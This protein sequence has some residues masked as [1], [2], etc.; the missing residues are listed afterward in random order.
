MKNTPESIE[1]LV[2]SLS[3]EIKVAMES[4]SYFYPLY[5]RLEDAVVEVKAAH[6]LKVRLIADSKIKSDKIDALVLAQLL[7]LG[8]PANQLHPAQGDS[9][10]PRPAP[11]QDQ[12]R[13][14]ENPGEE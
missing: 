12:P 9:P 2:D 10:S 7:R 14:A 5:N 3:P 11:P 8:L 1:E 13:K 6:P 4:C